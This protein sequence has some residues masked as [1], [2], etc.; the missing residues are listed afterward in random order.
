MLAMMPASTG[1]SACRMGDRRSAQ[2]TWC[3][4]ADDARQLYLAQADG[5]WASSD[6]GAT[7]ARFGEAGS[8]WCAGAGGASHTPWAAVC[9]RRERA[10]SLRWR[11]RALAARHER[12]VCRSA[13]GDPGRSAAGAAGQLQTAGSRAATR[14]AQAGRQRR[15]TAAGAATITVIAPVGYH[16][17]TAFAGSAGG[18]LA[19]ST[20]RGRTW[21]LLKQDLPPIRSVAAAR[22]A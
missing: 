18:Q 6:A 3:V 4:A 20:D 12:A 14:P 15:S 5:V 21:Q 8:G 9:H 11:G 10:V 19:T 22:L 7:W 1:I 16:I 13:A 17:D 2:R